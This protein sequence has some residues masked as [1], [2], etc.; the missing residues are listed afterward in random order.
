MRQWNLRPLSLQKN[1]RAD[2][3]YNQWIACPGRWNLVSSATT[4]QKT[5]QPPRQ[6]I[7]PQPRVAL[8]LLAAKQAIL[9]GV[10]RYVRQ[11]GPWRLFIQPTEDRA[12]LP[13]WLAGWEGDGIIG[14]ITD[15][16]TADLVLSTGLPFVD[17]RG[18]VRR[19]DIPLIRS[20]DEAIGRLAAEHLLERGFRHFGYVGPPGENWSDHRR[21]MF[22]RTASDADTSFQA[23][24]AA[25]DIAGPHGW[26]AAERE[27]AEWINRLPKPSGVMAANDKF[28]QRV[29]AA[30]R[31][32]GVRVPEELAVIGVDDDPATCEVCDPPLS[33]VAIDSEQQGY[34]AAALLHELMGGVRPQTPVLL[35]PSGV[36]T[37]Q[38]TDIL[39]IDDPLIADAV[40]FIRENACEGIGVAELLRQVPLSRSVLQRRF[41]QVFGMTAN[42]MIVQTRVKRAQQLLIESDLPI[43]RIAEIA[44]FRYQ[45]YL[46]AVFREK[47]GIT[48][49]QYRLQAGP[50]RHIED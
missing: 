41:R 34:K 7:R 25:L 35:Q 30:A 12:G 14:R 46:G 8:F 13:N 5:D 45:R 9:L 21:D 24:D 49:A 37:R 43:S 4:K 36:R 38:S 19:P 10:A 11:F 6:L 33:S 2:L 28:G 31:R 42:D 39:A 47:V 17:V 22:L 23:F 48:P 18:A 29:L 20:D 26:E 32:A 15:Q 27:L 16:E 3:R 44:G 40:R 1:G 50:G